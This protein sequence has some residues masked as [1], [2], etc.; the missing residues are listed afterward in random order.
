MK[1]IE[2]LKI[3]MRKR[4]AELNAVKVKDPVFDAQAQL[5]R[6]AEKYLTNVNYLTSEIRSCDQ[7]MKTAQEIA[8]KQ[9]AAEVERRKSL[10]ESQENHKILYDLILV[11]GLKQK[12]HFAQPAGVKPE[13]LPTIPKES[14][15]KVR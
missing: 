6:T 9:I 10:V 13:P 5:V 7:G 15:K 14:K 3:E 1:T 4:I 2:D 11:E 8:Q 12:P